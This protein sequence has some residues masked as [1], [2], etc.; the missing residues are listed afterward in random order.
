MKAVPAAKNSRLYP[1]NVKTEKY[2][3]LL[4]EQGRIPYECKKRVCKNFMKDK[5]S[6]YDRYIVTLNYK[7]PKFSTKAYGN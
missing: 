5:S 7:N 3:V 6:N 1:I 4:D 2:P